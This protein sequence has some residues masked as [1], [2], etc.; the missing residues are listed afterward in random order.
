MNIK[1]VINKI[2][3]GSQREIFDKNSLFLQMFERFCYQIAKKL[4]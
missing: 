1:K 2:V 4:H 3:G